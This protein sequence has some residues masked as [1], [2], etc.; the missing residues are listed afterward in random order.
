MA[1]GLRRGGVWRRSALLSQG[2]FE[3][4]RIVFGQLKM[5]DECSIG[6]GRWN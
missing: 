5:R 1:G 6:V 3:G 2:R 4:E